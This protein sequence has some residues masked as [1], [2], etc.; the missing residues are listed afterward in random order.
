MSKI[1]DCPHCGKRDFVYRN[2]RA[3][4]WIQ[5]YFNFD[6]VLFET[7]MDNLRGSNSKTFRCCSCKK[8][9]RDIVLVGRTLIPKE[10]LEGNDE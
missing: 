8:I 10:V 3:F 9:R 7:D 6:G 5:D 4:G 1:P 2:V